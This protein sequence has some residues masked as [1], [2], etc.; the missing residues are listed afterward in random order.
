MRTRSAVAAMSVVT[1]LSVSV[2]P[3]AAHAASPA[4]E[5]DAVFSNV[6]V[7]GGKDVV[8]GLTT[9]KTVTISWTAT[10]PDGILASWSYLY[11][12]PNV[13]DMNGYL[14]HYPPP[15]DCTPTSAART[16]VNCTLSFGVD[17]ARDFRKNILAGV[18]KMPGA[19]QDSG[20]DWTEIDVIGTGRFKRAGK[21]TV[22]ASPEPVKKG[23]T[24][25]VTGKLTR[26]NWESR[27]YTGYQGQAVKLQFRKKGSSTYT[28]LKTITTG[29]GGKLRTTTKATGDGYYRFVFAGTGTTGPSTAAGDY[30]DVR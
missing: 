19:V 18:W 26:A 4:A 8:L 25:T 21:V 17:A 23:R 5:A 12:G 29:S 6:S 14:P 9:R 24:I 2:T 7:N 3:M 15:G 1:A 13:D 27:T 30:V 28:T 11:N 10:D 16:T 20:D 22:N